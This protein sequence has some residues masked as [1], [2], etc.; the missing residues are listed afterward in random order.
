MAKLHRNP[1]VMIGAVI[2]VL[3]LFMPSLLILIL[4]RRLGRM[5]LPKK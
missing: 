4:I 3:L 1:L 5:T 2:V